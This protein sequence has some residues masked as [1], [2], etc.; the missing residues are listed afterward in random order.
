MESPEGF[1]R[2]LRER[3]RLRTADLFHPIWTTRPASVALPSWLAGVDLAS[4]E[5][6]L[7]AHWPADPGRTA[8]AEAARITSQ[9]CYAQFRKPLVCPSLPVG[10]TNSARLRGLYEFDPA[11]ASAPRDARH[12]H[13]YL[14]D[15][16]AHNRRDFLAPD[17]DLVRARLFEVLGT[18]ARLV[19]AD[20]HEFLTGAPPF[21]GLD[22]FWELSLAMQELAGVQE[23][24]AAG[25]PLAGVACSEP[26]LRVAALARPDG[27]LCLVWRELGA[28]EPALDGRIFRRCR[29]TMPW[30]RKG[31]PAAVQMDPPLALPL[32]VTP[33][34]EGLTVEMNAVETTA[35]ILVSA[36]PAVLRRA[37]ERLQTRLD[38]AAE[39]I[40]HGLEVRA[41]KAA[42]VERELASAGS[43]LRL[44]DEI[45]ETQQV[46]HEARAARETGNHAMAIEL[47]RAGATTLRRAGARHL[48]AAAA[49]ALP[50]GCDARLELWRRC[51]A[52]L[53]HFHREAARPVVVA[54]DP[55]YT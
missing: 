49:V 14:A 44:E 40:V 55:G 2:Y 10:V 18:G 5:Q 23:W 3:D 7:D 6:T 52:T 47:G 48:A 17:P 43:P 21:S 50:A 25:S 46:L 53:P 12:W 45:L 20:F 39:A 30:D 24:L 8:S 32:S 27:I 34:V 36:D 41:A 13:P 42:L 33:A 15:V 1:E 29:L 37:A 54:P 35:V 19:I 31:S 51:L 4:V 22:R 11:V 26:S 38:A 28:D 9:A 16:A